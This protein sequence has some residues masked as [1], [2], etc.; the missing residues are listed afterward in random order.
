MLVSYYPE[1]LCLPSFCSGKGQMGPLETHSFG[2]G[3]WGQICFLFPSCLSLSPHSP[4]KSVS[5]CVLRAWGDTA[6][7]SVGGSGGW[8]GCG[9]HPEVHMLMQSLRPVREKATWV[10]QQRKRWDLSIPTAG[11]RSN[12]VWGPG[13]L[14]ALHYIF[15]TLSDL[16]FTTTPGDQDCYPYFF[17]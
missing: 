11:L 3:G 6:C 13:P 10:T 16:I 9:H 8:Q 7:W 1:A 15:R 17:R 2:H 5:D 12:S 14:P 4:E